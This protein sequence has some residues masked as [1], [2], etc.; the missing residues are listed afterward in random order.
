M[1]KAMLRI[2]LAVIGWALVFGCLYQLEVHPK[3]VVLWVGIITGL[4]LFFTAERLTF[5]AMFP[6]P[7][8]IHVNGIPPKRFQR[9]S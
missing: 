9:R 2:G 5:W 4:L 1:K 3:S 7:M 6:R 8:A